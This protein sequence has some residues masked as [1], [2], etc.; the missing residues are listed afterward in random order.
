MSLADHHIEIAEKYKRDLQTLFRIEGMIIP[1]ARNI[2]QV[3]SSG[4][5][6]EAEHDFKTRLEPHIK[7]IEHVQQHLIRTAPEEY[8]NIAKRIM[9]EIKDEEELLR[10]I[11]DA[12]RTN[13]EELVEKAVKL[14]KRLSNEYEEDRRI[15]N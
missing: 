6:K 2:L 3:F 9:Q 13:K 4:A 5:D 15:T 11:H 7:K 10:T 8:V 1:E 12:L 14:I